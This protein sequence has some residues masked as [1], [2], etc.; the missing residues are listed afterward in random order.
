MVY[1]P[2]AVAPATVVSS[3]RRP[4]LKPNDAS[5]AAKSGALPSPHRLS[6]SSWPEPQA[7]VPTEFAVEGMPRPSKPIQLSERPKPSDR[8]ASSSHTPQSPQVPSKAAAKASGSE[9]ES[10]PA[11]QQPKETKSHNGA[12]VPS[13]GPL[14]AP[15][16][17]EGAG[18]GVRAE[19]Q[20]PEEPLPTVGG[21]STPTGS[22]EAP[23]GPEQATEGT[24]AQP[25]SRAPAAVPSTVPPKA[26]EGPEQ[27]AWEMGAVALP[28][29]SLQLP[30]EPP[31]TVRGASTSTGS[32]TALQERQGA[33]EGT[34]AEAQSTA[35]AAEPSTGPPETP[36]GT[37]AAR[38]QLSLLSHP[39]DD[40]RSSASFVMISTTPQEAL[41]I[42]EEA[43]IETVTEGQSSAGGLLSTT[44]PSEYPLEREAA[45]ERATLVELQCPLQPS[46]LCTH[47]PRVEGSTCRVE[48]CSPRAQE[49]G[50][51]PVGKRWM[52][53]LMKPRPRKDKAGHAEI[54]QAG[55]GNDSTVEVIDLVEDAQEEERGVG[56]W[57]PRELQRPK[58][59]EPPSV[60][61]V[62][63][64][65]LHQPYPSDTRQEV[66]QGV[67]EEQ[68]RLEELASREE[69]AG[70][71]VLTEVAGERGSGEAG[72]GPGATPTPSR[73]GS[74]G[75]HGQD[76]GAHAGAAR[77]PGPRDCESQLEQQV[78]PSRNTNIADSPAVAVEGHP[79]G[80]HR[81]PRAEPEEVLSA[82]SPC[83][84]ASALP[85]L[86]SA[87]GGSAA[88]S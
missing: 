46:G 66:V 5:N 57:A 44:G 68:E 45:A 6:A 14:E 52:D 61:S 87:Q 21:A 85:L 73:A 11:W 42:P 88:C 56:V 79:A 82:N 51:V 30:E 80:N 58:P 32:P 17:P 60:S 8:S 15:Q 83:S 22:P 84:P 7:K 36:Q 48:T 4:Q 72:E 18:E 43:A 64:D 49:S 69:H 63:T 71:E 39:P 24:A 19:L 62:P 55:G 76:S 12:A 50:R 59:S 20:P 10:F 67:R 70:M 9:S 1:N 3:P 33:T 54:T 28:S 53:R 29:P 2:M 74:W 86:P 13:T 34:A 65:S 40:Q 27:A 47:P 16:G 35:G 77:S 75:G 23:Q 31:P 81:R 26:S 78:E 41:T 25:Q 37:E 38:E